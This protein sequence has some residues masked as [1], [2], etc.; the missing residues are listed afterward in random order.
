MIPVHMRVD[1]GVNVGR[2]DASRTKDICSVPGNLSSLSC[3]SPLCHPR[4]LTSGLT[5]ETSSWRAF[6]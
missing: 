5:I 6:E 4:L 1:D 3:S 2:L